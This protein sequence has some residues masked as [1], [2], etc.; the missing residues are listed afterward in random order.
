MTSPISQKVYL[1]TNNEGYELKC[2]FEGYKPTRFTLKDKSKTPFKGKGKFT[3]TFGKNQQ[4]PEFLKKEFKRIKA[5]NIT[6]GFKVAV[7]DNITVITFEQFNRWGPNTLR[8]AFVCGTA[9]VV[10]VGVAATAP[11]WGAPVLTTAVIG[12]LGGMA[13]GFGTKGLGYTLKT[14]EEDYNV[15]DCIKECVN[16]GAGGGVGGGVAAASAALIPGAGVFVSIATQ[17]TAGVASELTERW[18]AGKAIEPKDVRNAALSGFLGAGAGA[19][20]YAGF[21]KEVGNAIGKNIARG[22]VVGGFQAGCTTALRNHLDGEESE[23]NSVLESVL[24]GVAFGAIHGGLSAFVRQQQEKAAISAER[25]NLQDKALAKLC[26][27]IEGE[28][29]E[30]YENR[31]ALVLDEIRKLDDKALAQLVSEL[32]EQKKSSESS[33]SEIEEPKKTSESSSSEHS[34]QHIELDRQFKELQEM[35][36]AHLLET[37]LTYREWIKEIFAHGFK[38]RVPGSKHHLTYEEA[39]LA[40]DR[41]E[42][43]FYRGKETV[44]WSVDGGVANRKFH[45]D[46]AVLR[47]ALLESHLSIATH[48]LRA[49]VNVMVTKLGFT[50]ELRKMFDAY[51]SNVEQIHYEITTLVHGPK[52]QRW[53]NG[54]CRI[55]IDHP[56]IGFKKVSGDAKFNQII[57]AIDQGYEVLVVK[58]G[59]TRY[60]VLGSTDNKNFHTHLKQAETTAISAASNLPPEPP[61][62]N[63]TSPAKPPVPNS[64]LIIT[65][66][67]NLYKIDSNSNF[68]TDPLNFLIQFPPKRT[69]PLPVEFE[70]EKPTEPSLPV[71]ISEISAPV[72]S[73][74]W[75]RLLKEDVTAEEVQEYYVENIK[76]SPEKENKFRKQ[77]LKHILSVEVTYENINEL[78][79][80]AYFLENKMNKPKCIFKFTYGLT[81]EQLEYLKERNKKAAEWLSPSPDW[82]SESNNENAPESTFEATNHQF[83]ALAE[84]D[85]LPTIT[86]STELPAAFNAESESRLLSSFQIGPDLFFQSQRKKAHEKSSR[87]FA[88][89]KSRKKR[90]ARIE[91]IKKKL[92]VAPEGLKARLEEKLLRLQSGLN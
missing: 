1:I 28:S 2:T 86:S 85:I 17:A 45:S 32:E 27:K 42:I 62:P 10:G 11:I 52:V 57:K 67:A 89:V 21:G 76:P 8:S 59:Q 81:K 36:A 23:K 4:S 7:K 69:F 83:N 12:V 18:F 88:K 6:N 41:G 65:P 80:L 90:K 5:E 61:V 71:P 37:E 31:K 46:M 92:A 9:A 79:D 16:G 68:K 33:S 70:A 20:A 34:Q 72:I 54:G 77:I 55:Y 78:F 63:S 75:R 74:D 64:N 40:A 30:S 35:A 87:Q 53:L 22:G 19:V 60:R 58:Y 51:R 47:T 84:N 14:N 56:V 49:F 13:A 26:P 29:S 39:I 66:K 3:F 24:M 15:E 91:E 48:T 44:K 38:A 50:S 82:M 25:K 73:D 43:I